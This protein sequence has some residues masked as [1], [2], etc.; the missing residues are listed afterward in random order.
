[1]RRARH[2]AWPSFFLALFRVRRCLLEVADLRQLVPVGKGK[3]NEADD[4]DRDREALPHRKPVRAEEVAELCI[5]KTHELDQEAEDAVKR[6]ERADERA[7]GRGGF[8]LESAKRTKKIT[9]PS[10]MAS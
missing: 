9:S 7:L 4:E 8:F 3:D 5:R 1:M 2:Q 10:R 6:E